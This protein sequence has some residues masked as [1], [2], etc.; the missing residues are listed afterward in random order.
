MQKKKINKR[1]IIAITII[2][3]LLILLLSQT[4]IQSQ[5]K[6]RLAL[7]ENT[8]GEAVEVKPNIPIV[9]A[10][11]IPVKWNGNEFVITTK[12]D[13]DWYNYREGKPAYVMLNDGY[14]RSELER[15]VEEKQL[16]SNNVGADVS[17]R[18]RNNIY[19]DTTICSK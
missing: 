10:G 11:M 13:T 3:I 12:E 4:I 1:I 14:Y 2:A 18:L 16:A 6:K 7:L 17:V 9:S 15:G 19:V 8:P 5:N